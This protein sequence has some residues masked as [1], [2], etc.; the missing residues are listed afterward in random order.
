VFTHLAGQDQSDHDEFCVE[1]NTV[2]A[3]KFLYYGA[4]LLQLLEHVPV[5]IP[6]P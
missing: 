6:P 5:P 1:L 4:K 2:V 3:G